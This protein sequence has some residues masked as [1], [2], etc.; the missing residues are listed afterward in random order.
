MIL[1]RYCLQGRGLSLCATTPCSKPSI[2]LRLSHSKQLKLSVVMMVHGEDF[3]S[4]GDGTASFA[5]NSYLVSR[6]TSLGHA[7]AQDD[8]ST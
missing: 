1:E 5:P 7:R 6:G 3:P 4:Q 2:A 8:I